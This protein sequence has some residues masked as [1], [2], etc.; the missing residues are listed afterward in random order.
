MLP[1]GANKPSYTQQQKQLH[2]GY[3]LIADWLCLLCTLLC[4]SAS[5]NH[6]STLLHFCRHLHNILCGPHALDLPA[7]SGALPAAIIL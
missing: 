1:S 4:V 3:L 7:R 5:A 2:L 6:A